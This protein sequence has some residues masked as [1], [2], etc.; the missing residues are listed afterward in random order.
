MQGALVWLLEGVREVYQVAAAGGAFILTGNLA[1][2]LAGGFAAQ[3]LMS[4]YQRLGLRRSMERRA[5]VMRRRKA[6]AKE[7]EV[8][9][10]RQEAAARE[11]AAEADKRKAEGHGEGQAEAEGAGEA[12]DVGGRERELERVARVREEPSGHKSHEG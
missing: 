8:H 5:E 4:A 7:R 12:G 6:A 1:A 9:R 2:P 10:L 3:C 11:L